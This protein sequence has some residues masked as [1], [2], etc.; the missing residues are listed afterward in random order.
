MRRCS[1]CRAAQGAPRA[2][3][4]LTGLGISCVLETNRPRTY[5]DVA[6]A[7]LISTSLFGYKDQALS[8]INSLNLDCVKCGASNLKGNNTNCRFEHFEAL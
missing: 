5:C 7:G 2:L 6:F 8:S 4:S 1:Y 3:G